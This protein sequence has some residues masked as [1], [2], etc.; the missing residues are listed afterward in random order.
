MKIF[1]SLL[2]F[3]LFANAGVCLVKPL[4]AKAFQNVSKDFKDDKD[5]DKIK[6]LA[7]SFKNG[8]ETIIANIAILESEVS[9]VK[10]AQ[11][12]LL[13]KENEVLK[14]QTYLFENLNETRN[15]KI[16]K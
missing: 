2:I 13:Y 3:T 1:I 5:S 9:K 12:R 11:A 7:T 16:F 10:E 14:N 6:R 15:K 4:G 8:F